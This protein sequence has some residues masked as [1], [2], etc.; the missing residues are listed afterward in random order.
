MKDKVIN[1]DDTVIDELN[2]LLLDFTFNSSTYNDELYTTN[3]ASKIIQELKNNHECYL[4]I[5]NQA[6]SYFQ[7]LG[8]AENVH[9]PE[10]IKTAITSASLSA[11]NGVVKNYTKSSSGTG[12]KNITLNGKVKGSAG[13]YNDKINVYKT[14]DSKIDAISEI[15]NNTD[16][17]IIGIENDMYKI[18]LTDG[19]IGYISKNDIEVSNIIGIGNIFTNDS[20][21]NIYLDS[22][23]SNVVTKANNG[24]SIRIMGEENSMFKVLINDKIGYV[25]KSE[26]IIKSIGD[27]NGI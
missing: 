27:S 4:E 12:K 22:S 20:S 17:T 16:V 9:Q 24:S 7:K 14:A 25:K 1:Y 3:Y 15:E 8:E 13:I 19:K 18:K 6:K 26:V 23:L 2:S 11:A 21:V 10:F 5:I